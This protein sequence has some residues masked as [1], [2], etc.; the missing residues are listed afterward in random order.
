MFRGGLCKTQCD[1]T[2]VK[3]NPTQSLPSWGRLYPP[4]AI[5]IEG[6]VNSIQN[7]F[8]CLDQR[9]GEMDWLKIFIR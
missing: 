8:H 5:E 7:R 4:V 2:E 1:I 3:I 9:I 6:M